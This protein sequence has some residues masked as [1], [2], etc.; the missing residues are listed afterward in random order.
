MSIRTQ[1]PLVRKVL[2]HTNKLTMPIALC[3]TTAYPGYKLVGVKVKIS[4]VCLVRKALVAASQAIKI[5]SIGERALAE[6]DYSTKL[7]IIVSTF[8]SLGS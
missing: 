8:I 3:W 7:A 2:V 1:P 6:D 4:R 5:K